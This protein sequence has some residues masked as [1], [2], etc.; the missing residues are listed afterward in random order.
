MSWYQF[1][2]FAQKNQWGLQL[3]I[4][5]YIDG[6]SDPI[7]VWFRQDLRVHDNP[8][9]TAAVASGAPVVPVFLFDAH[10]AGQWF[11]GGASKWWLHHAL[12]DLT[13]SLS[14][15]G[16]P[17]IIR[18]GDS[19]R[20][21]EDI[22]RTTGAKSVVWNRR[23]EPYAIAQDTHIK[24]TLVAQSIHVES[25]NARLLIEPWQVKTGSG[26]PY[27]VFTPFWKTCLSYLN[28]HRVEALLPAPR[29]AHTL[30]TLPP[31]LCVNDLNLTPTQ[32]DWAGG[33]RN[34]WQPTESGAHQ[35][36]SHFID[37]AIGTYK[38]DRDFPAKPSTSRL[39]PY[40]AFGQISPRQCWHAVRNAMASEQI[41]LRDHIE[42][43]HFITELGWR[44]FAYHLLYHF[45]HTVTQPLYAKFQNF[46]WRDAP[47][48]LRAWQH[49]QTGYP[50]V[51]AGMRQLWQTGWIHNRVRMV[52]GSFLV[53]HLVLPWQDGAHW[54]W[55]T[56]VDADLASN[57]LGWQWI[58]GCGADAAPYFRI[59]N[60]ILQS[61]KFDA[62]GAYIKKFVPELKTMNADELHAPWEHPLEHPK[63]Y[64]QPLVEHSFARNRALEAL[65]KLRDLTSP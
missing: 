19:A 31:S 55:D 33:L 22:I 30:S 53:K 38:T 42:A 51:D 16:L 46:P 47:H 62:D 41:S 26:D 9:L 63:T 25:F 24:E 4:T 28:Q 14:K 43:E 37:G 29:K 59:F 20:E 7:L 48:E 45:P 32:P 5:V 18:R 35:H 10:A 8:A 57:T 44:E 58:A 15:L 49:G 65:A 23:Y 3:N 6:M 11:Y 34:E 39:S 1:Y 12:N 27:R 52:V 50:L 54:F 2:A 36:L 21:L 13:Q 60:P 56:L 64:P 61:K 40:L 17:L